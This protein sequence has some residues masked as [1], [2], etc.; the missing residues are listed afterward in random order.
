[1]NPRHIISLLIVV[2]ITACSNPNTRPQRPLRPVDYG[3]ESPRPAQTL[4]ERAP[5]EFWGYGRA[6][7]GTR[8]ANPEI[9]RADELSAADD[10]TAAR[11]ILM[12]VNEKALA[13]NEREALQIRLVAFDLISN[14]AAAA[15]RSLSNFFT[16]RGQKVEDIG[17]QFSL[18]LAYA[19]G[20]QGDIDQSLA[21]FS[22]VAQVHGP[23]T[24]DADMGVRLLLESVSSSRFEELALRWSG[25]DYLSQFFGQERQR[26]AQ[27][28]GAPDV[29]RPAGVPFWKNSSFAPGS[30]IV[31]QGVVGQGG[32]F[33]IG[34]V[35]PLSG[36]YATLGNNTKNGMELALEVEANGM[37]ASLSVKDDL[38][39]VSKAVAE[40][41]SLTTAE[42][43]A[44]VLGPLLSDPALAVANSFRGSGVSL[45]TFS[46][47]A[48]FAPGD[49]LFRLGATTQS[50]VG[51][52][53]DVVA[54]Q[55]GLRRYALVFPQSAN[56]EEF[57][58]EF[59]Q[60]IA[61]RG[62][63]LVFE[64]SYA[65]DSADSFL[66][67]GSQLAEHSPQAIFCPDGAASA[68][69]L[70][71]SLPEALRKSVVPLGMAAWDDTVA[72]SNAKS[73]LRNAIF[74]SP[75]FAASEREMVRRFVDAY[76]AKFNKSP[77]FLAAQ[78]YDATTMVLAA[79]RRQ[80][81]E[82][83]SV[84]DALRGISRYAGLTGDI[85][86]SS[87]G[88]IARQFAVLQLQKGN[89][90]ELTAGATPKV[91]TT[92]IIRAPRGL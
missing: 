71:T 90:V 84:N 82:A 91:P 21:W 45:L 86:P 26:R 52:L 75:F 5:F 17:P 48:N 63:E 80:Q 25:E 67:L 42:R 38:G 73:A 29:V 62:L 85:T 88:E 31:D 46:K 65:K 19:Y 24:V 18:M 76:R 33:V 12:Q 11:K 23:A 51:S 74:V 55:L 37:P 9:L 83:I 30:A 27:R 53:L 72:L 32:T 68:A 39:D 54:G 6:L 16:A 1:M 64:S 59:R 77:D 50:Q 57:A 14:N 58:A 34:A 92:E 8:I 49:N 87:N 78:G 28:A 66:S 81:N 40:A 35:L 43:A 56:G 70:F 2:S 47:N 20:Q 69:Q 15:L 41:Q 4:R 44:V 79:G 61:A 60:Q 7:D 22:R 10:L 89:L 36:Q 3:H 13:P